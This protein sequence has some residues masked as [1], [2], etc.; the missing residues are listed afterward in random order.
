MNRIRITSIALVSILFFAR[1]AQAAPVCTAQPG[2]L[3]NPATTPGT[4]NPN[5]PIE[6]IV[7]IMQENHSFDQ[8]LG[9]L[10]LPQFYGSAI[11]GITDALTY[12]DEHDKPA[13]PYH[14]TELCID[15]V[16]HEW[17]PQHRMW[18]Q[19]KNDRFLLENGKRA[20]GYFDHTDL[21]FYY[22]LANEFA[23]ADRYFCSSLTQ[24]IPN[25]MYLFAGTSFG[26]IANDIPKNTSEF[27][28]P[29]IFDLMTKHGVSWKYYSDN[30]LIGYTALFQ[31]ML[32]ANIQKMQKISDFEKD[33][34]NGTLP[35]VVFIDSL[36]ENEDEHPNANIQVGQKWVADRVLALLNS[37]YWKNSVLFFTYDENGGF[38]DHVPPPEAC[39]PDAIPPMLKSNSEPGV[40]DRL[41]FR[42][43]FI[44][45]S[46]YV[47]R[48]FVSHVTYDH[49]S[50][51]KFIQTTHNLP[52]LTFRDANADAML[53]LFDFKNPRYDLPKLVS[54]NIDSA[55]FCKPPHDSDELTLLKE[56][57][58]R[59]LNSLR[60]PIDKKYP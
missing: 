6:H 22:S 55:R 38:A 3:P 17:D 53:D 60:P 47:K 8:Y 44:A 2:A 51:L 26:H 16:G 52:A 59:G 46:P 5:I 31:P 54:A 40:F 12:P 45:V 1:A 35:Q 43:P 18:N 14:E 15:D 21:P 33:L 23:T 7:V 41:G 50:I 57:E 37:S 20:I 56:L 19:G 4:K 42:V 34:A 11:D 29:T 25:R 32:H 30:K 58:K 48:H 10:T 28:Q 9:K 49:T 27:A 13:A 36:M 39:V 24:T